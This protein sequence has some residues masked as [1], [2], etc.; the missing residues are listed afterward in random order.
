MP[1]KGS[2]KLK[3]II[4]PGKELKSDFLN[5]WE[6]W[7]PVF[8]DRVSEVTKLSMEFD[9]SRDLKVTSIPTITKSSPNSGG[10]G[11]SAGL[12]LDLLAWWQDT[13]MHAIL[14]E[15]MKATSSRAINFELESI[16]SAFGRMRDDL[17]RRQPRLLRRTPLEWLAVSDETVR[18]KKVVQCIWGK[19]L[20]FGRLGFKEEP[21]K[22]RVFA[23]VNLLTQALM[24]PLHEWIFARLRNIPTDGTFDQMG[25]VSR[26]LDRFKGEEW[27]ASYDLSAATDRLPVAIQ[28]SLLKPLL[29]ERL[30]HL[31]A[32][33]LVGRPYGLPKVAKSYNLGYMSV[34]YKVGQPMGA[35][36]SWAM[37]AL[38][39][40]AIV[41]YAAFLAY[42]DKPLWFPKYALLG[43]DFLSGTQC[44][45][46]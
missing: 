25:P 21:G 16:F 39:H 26:L 41:Q 24:H 11:A 29:G 32:Y 28:V 42:P 18:R 40:H 9:P 8:L 22:I 17:I 37:L 36:S 30:A 14:G 19:P 6:R 4:S 31:W 7:I 10:F 43:A 12:P 3:T 27:F 33:I 35:L 23:M 13:E 20:F 38:T 1:F 45:G 34:Y 2:L 15:W 5:A 46:E 44:C